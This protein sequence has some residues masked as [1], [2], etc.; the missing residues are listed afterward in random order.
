MRTVIAGLLWL[1]AAAKLARYDL[2]LLEEGLLSWAPLLTFTIAYEVGA[3]VFILAAP[4]AFSWT[5]TLITFSVFL[6][7]STYAAVADRG[8]NC[9]SPTLNAKAMMLIDLVVLT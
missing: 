5:A 3:G 2:I 9:L 6:A 7:A 8:C 4:S 1:A